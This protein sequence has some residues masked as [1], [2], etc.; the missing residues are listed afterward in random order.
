[1]VPTELSLLPASALALWPERVRFY[2]ASGSPPP[3]GEIVIPTATGYPSEIGAGPYD[4]CIG[5]ITVERPAVASTLSGGS[6]LSV[7]LPASGTVVFADPLTYAGLGDVTADGNLT[8]AVGLRQRPLIR[9]PAVAVTFV[10][11]G[12]PPDA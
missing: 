5:A 2:Y 8:L 4:R 3:P 10:E 1:M 11:E 12:S 6:G 9:L 7:S